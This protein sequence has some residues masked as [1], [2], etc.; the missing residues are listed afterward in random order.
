MARN[1][2]PKHRICRRYGMKLCDSFKC[3]VTRRNY[4]PGAHGQKKIRKMSDYGRQLVEKQKAKYVYGLLERQFK[5]TL[6]RA[7]QMQ[8][9]IGTNLLMLLERR[10]DNVVF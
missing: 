10:L 7:K 3:P 1:L 6:N 8:G 9:D 5:T 4:P 2:D